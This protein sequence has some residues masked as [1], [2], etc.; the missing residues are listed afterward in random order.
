MARKTK[1]EAQQTRNDILSAAL[2]LFYE[3][4]YTKTKLTD[5][6]DSLGLS[7]GAIYWHFKSK[8]DLFLTLM[9]N[10]D[11]KIN[12]KL[13][14]LVEKT[15]TPDDLRTFINEY[16]LLVLKDV[17]IKKYYSVI[18]Y[19]IEWTSD[20]SKVTDVLEKQNKELISLFK[21]LIKKWKIT[22]KTKTNISSGNAASIL[23]NLVDGVVMNVNQSS[24][25]KKRLELL[26]D[27]LDIFYKGIG[28]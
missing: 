8:D 14:P 9:N 11:E 2:N 16:V 19:K 26:N 28:L 5:I 17:E 22:K 6:A 4:G 1:E 15:K 23:A 20:M 13:L 18:V 24:S 12:Q 3:Q 25:E 27:T 7:K 21:Y 10:I